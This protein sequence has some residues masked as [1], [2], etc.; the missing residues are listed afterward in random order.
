MGNLAD[1]LPEHLDA[2]RAVVSKISRDVNLIDDL[3][4][5]CCARV[6]EKEA[7]WD[8]NRGSLKVWLNAIARNLTLDF[9]KKRK[10]EKEVFAHFYED[11]VPPPKQISEEE[12]RWVLIQFQNLPQPLKEVL[13]LK[14]YENLSTVSIAKKLGISQQAVSK[15]IQKAISILRREA[16]V[17]G[18]L[19]ILLPWDWGFKTKV[20][21]GVLATTLVTSYFF[22]TDPSTYLIA[23]IRNLKNTIVTAYLDESIVPGKNYIY[24]ATFQIAW[25]KF[26]NLLNSDIHLRN[27]PK[28][29]SFLNQNSFSQHDLSDKDYVAGAGFVKDGIVNRMQQDL[30]TK[31]DQGKDPMIENLHLNPRDILIYAF[32]YKNLQF[33]VEFESLDEDL[34]FIEQRGGSNNVKAFGIKKLSKEEQWHREL[35]DQVSILSYQSNEDFIIELKSKSVNDR[36]LLAKVQ[37]SKTVGET[38]TQV[39]TL[40]K[41]KKPIYLEWGDCLGI[42]KFDFDL[43][44][45]YQELLHKNLRMPGFEDYFIEEA[46]QTITFKLNEKGAILKSRMFSIVEYNSLEMEKKKLFF[47]RPFLLILIEKGAENPYLA[48]WVDN[49]EVLVKA[50]KQPSS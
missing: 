48:I 11:T 33:E 2:I 6:I 22:L 5:D 28:L 43:T 47:D 13:H 7:L 32:L 16:S 50:E 14:Y 15:R 18:L 20:I 17:A 44:H 35:R 12:I 25:D 29:V 39:M 30:I 23:D 8:K 10:R 40:I 4:Q 9:L 1:Q 24:C 19:S 46:L 41:D 45:H 42:P 21:A 37:P 26:K 36:L 31:F 3:S 49:V 34:A 38:V 27:E